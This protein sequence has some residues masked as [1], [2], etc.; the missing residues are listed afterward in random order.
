MSAGFQC[1]GLRKGPRLYIAAFSAS[2]CKYVPSTCIFCSAYKVTSF[3]ISYSLLVH[4][5]WFV[6]VMAVSGII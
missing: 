2:V 3:I 1:S 6:I 5:G 4:I